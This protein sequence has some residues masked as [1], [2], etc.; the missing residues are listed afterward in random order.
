MLNFSQGGVRAPTFFGHAKFEV[1][2]FWNFFV[3]RVLWTE[4]FRG[5]DWKPTFFD[6]TEFEVKNILEF[7]CLQSTVNLNCLGDC[8]LGINTFW[9]Y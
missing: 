2:I 1:K 3:Y 8:D 9:S 7:F 4:F 5:G 6:H